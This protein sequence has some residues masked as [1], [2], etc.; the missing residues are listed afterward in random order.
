MMM[1]VKTKFADMVAAAKRCKKC[2]YYDNDVMRVQTWSSRTAVTTRAKFEV[3]S[4]WYSATWRISYSSEVL[5]VC[6]AAS[7]YC[8]VA[9]CLCVCVSACDKSGVLGMASQRRPIRISLYRLMKSFFALSTIRAMYH[10]IT[11]YH[12]LLAPLD[13]FVS[14]GLQICIYICLLWLIDQKCRRQFNSL[15]KCHN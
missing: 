1:S 7:N 8:F 6:F 15:F 10:I 5:L 14:R 9:I 3:P 2:G 4:Q 12:T 13:N 11:M